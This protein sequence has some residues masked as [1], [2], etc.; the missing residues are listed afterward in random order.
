MTRKFVVKKEIRTIGLDF[1]SPKRSIG[2]VVRGGHYLDGVVVFPAKFASK[3]KSIAM[4]IRETR[5]FPELKLIMV[6]NSRLRLN[7]K[8]VE[9]LTRLPVIE[10]TSAGRRAPGGF[11]TCKVGSKKLQVASS[12]PFE[13][14]EEVLSTTWVT[15]TLPEPL[16][17][18]HLVYRSRFFGKT[19]AF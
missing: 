15:G 4:A 1:C 13:I 18:A 8:L 17:I 11:K 12:L 5:F 7:A 6:H 10:V 3:S 14:L 2:A 19:R 16:R 9:R